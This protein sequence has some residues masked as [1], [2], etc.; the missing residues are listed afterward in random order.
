MQH[1]RIKYYVPVI[2]L[3]FTLYLEILLRYRMLRYRMLNSKRT[4]SDRHP[5]K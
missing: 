4:R 5:L 3:I 1:E 2:K